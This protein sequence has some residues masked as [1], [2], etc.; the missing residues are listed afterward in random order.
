MTSI[1]V[2]RVEPED[3]PEWLRMRLLLWPNDTRE[4]LQAGMDV[5]LADAGEQP[6]FIALRPD[7]SPCGFLEGG[8]RKYADGCETG[9]VGY[10]EGWYV[11]E[12]SR[13]QGVGAALVRA[14]EDWTRA[15]GLTEM[16]SD[17]WLWNETSIA[18]HQ[19]LGYVEMERLVHFAKK[20]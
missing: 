9:P 15:R 19:R 3:K 10:I 5:L 14:M 2:R 17:T 13:L 11:D 1:T 8:T 4:E 12:D 20:L 16:G 6:V 7:L 18:A